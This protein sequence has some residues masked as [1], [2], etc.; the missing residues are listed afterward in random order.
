[1][2]ITLR[3]QLDKTDIERTATIPPSLSLFALHDIVQVLF[4]LED[5]DP[6]FIAGKGKATYSCGVQEGTRIRGVLHYDARLHTVGELLPQPG[7]A[8]DDNYLLGDSW[9]IIITRL[10]D[11]AADADA[12]ACTHVAGPNAVEYIGGPAGLLDFIENVKACKL[13]S[14]DADDE[15]VLSPED[16]DIVEYGLAD[17]DDRAAYLAGPDPDALTTVLRKCV[18][19]HLAAASRVLLFKD[20]QPNS[21]CPCGSGKKFKDCCRDKYDENGFPMAVEDDLSDDE[22]DDCLED[23]FEEYAEEDDEEETEDE[24]ADDEEYEEEKEPS[25]P[26]SASAPASTVPLRLIKLKMELQGTRSK[27][28]VTV[29]EEISFYELHKV[30]QEMFGFDNDH[31]WLFRDGRSGTEYGCDVSSW[32]YGGRYGPDPFEHAI[33][34][35]FRAHKDSARYRYDF[36]DDWYVRITRMA[37]PKDGLP[38]CLESTG[39]NAID[40]IGGP[41]GL[42]DFIAR[43]EKLE[44][45]GAGDLD[46]E[47]DPNGQGFWGYETRKG[48]RA[49]LAGPTKEELSDWLAS[50]ADSWRVLI[51]ERK[52]AAARRKLFRNVSRNDPCPCGSGKKY[53]KCCLGKYDE[54]GYPIGGDDD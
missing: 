40:D 2:N 30:I 47:D 52:E 43:M 3:C 35:T 41:L 27:R 48:R 7:A 10:D 45:D 46:E 42:N 51:A 4:G 12:I 24:D 33:S 54:N 18:L 8:I 28:V 53:K 38:A 26:S 20:A 37:D 9:K 23:D 19:F 13:N 32:E 49:F 22:D 11:P 29:P 14:E 25:P 17:P 50:Q 34:E 31:L 5:C 6:W 39:T 21:P 1:M 16:E 15:S 44:R 36:G